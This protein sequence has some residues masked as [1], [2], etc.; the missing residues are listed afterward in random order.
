M[1]HHCPWIYNCVGFNNYKYFYLLLLYSV[2]SLHVIIWS[3]AESVSRV[4]DPDTP[5]VTM[6]CVVFCETIAIFL[7]LLL[8]L[9]F[10]F[11]TWL[12]LCANSTVEFCEK[13]MPKNDK[14]NQDTSRSSQTSIYD[15]GFV[16]N[17][18]AVLGPNPMMWLIPIETT[19]GDG[20]FYVPSS[21]N[22]T[23]DFDAGKSV[24]RKTHRTIQRIP[25][26]QHSTGASDS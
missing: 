10:G 9:F 15:L 18:K 8:T 1:D 22:L 20:L 3:M 17:V 5:A 13:K 6:F 4:T 25:L 26:A 14:R 7:G 23:Q 12:M 11:H 2:I 16:G 24:R 19:I 21:S